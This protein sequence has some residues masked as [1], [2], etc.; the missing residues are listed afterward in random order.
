MGIKTTETSTGT[1]ARKLRFNLFSFA[2]ENKATQNVQRWK[3][4]KKG[5]INRAMRN[6]ERLRS[7]QRPRVE[8]GKNV[9][10]VH[11]ELELKKI[12]RLE[13]TILT[14]F[15]FFAVISSA[16]GLSTPVYFVGT[17]LGSWFASI[18]WRCYRHHLK[19][20]WHLVYIHAQKC[21]HCGKPLVSS[22]PYVKSVRQ[23]GMAHGSH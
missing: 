2:H 11:S 12:M 21:P 19:C 13:L 8:F 15:L 18:A 23:E 4:K 6:A 14:V 9:A 5:K 20:Y 22:G 10:E 1:S 17:V 3:R 16:I 7:I